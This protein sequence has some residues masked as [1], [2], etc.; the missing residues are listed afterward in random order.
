METQFKDAVAAVIPSPGAARRFRNSVE[1]IFGGV[2]LRGANVLDVGGGSGLHSF[3][4]AVHGAAEVVCLEP[5]ADGA[6]AEYSD[7]TVRS[8]A[9]VDSTLVR[10]LPLKLQDFVSDPKR[11]DIVLLHNSINHLDEQ[12]CMKLPD[13]ADSLVSYKRLFEKLAGLANDNALIIVTDCSSKNFFGL[14]RVKNPFAPTI[15]WQKHHPPSIWA[16]LLQEAGFIDPR[17]RWL[18]PQRLGRPGQTLLGNQVCA[19]FLSSYFKLTV[20]KPM[21]KGR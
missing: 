7:P 8:A 18:V 21:S 1:A 17:V 9:G 14:A 10:F 15:E 19:Y 20:R 3:Y 13:D 11:F 6:L 16:N 12:G 4:A 2:Q 5:G